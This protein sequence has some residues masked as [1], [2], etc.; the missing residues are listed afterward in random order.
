MPERCTDV[1]FGTS[2][3]TARSWL[4]L[5]V[6]FTS[7]TGG[8]S[9]QQPSGEQVPKSEA[10][11]QQF[12]ENPRLVAYYREAASNREGHVVVWVLYDYR[13]A[14]ESER[15]GRRYI[16]QKGQQEV[17]CAGNR[18]RTVFFS[19]HSE[20][21]GN[22][23][24]VYSGTTPTPWEPNSPE[25]IARALST[26]VCK[27]GSSP[28]FAS[29]RDQDEFLAANLKSS[30]E[31][32]NGQTPLQ[33]DEETQMQSVVALQKTLTFNLR[34]PRTSSESVDRAAFERTARENLNHTVCQSKATR[35]LIDLGVQYVYLYYGNDGKLITRFAIDKYRCGV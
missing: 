30:A 16:S 24:V 3:M 9:A 18:S 14:Q 17:D 29:Q 32:L 22:G 23:Q 15:S 19:W 12:G 21:M 26:V 2:I 34:L 33:L 31:E 4:V 8:V 13:L 6:A 35:D 10:T 27:A 25:S 20:R 7:M 1:L 28:R 5:A 11:W